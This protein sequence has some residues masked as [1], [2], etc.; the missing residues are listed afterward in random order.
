MEEI[1]ALIFQFVIEVGLQIFGGAAIDAAESRRSKDK[2]EAGCG[3]ILLFAVFGGIT[4]G[5]S[6]LVAPN[7]LLPNMG[8][9]IANLVVSPLIAGLMSYLAA[10]HLFSDGRDADQHFWRGCMF[11]FAFG[12]VRFAYAHR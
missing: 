6:L 7:L 5:L 2:G 10:K 8:L 12:V 4:G 1:I 3:W 9:R 11:A